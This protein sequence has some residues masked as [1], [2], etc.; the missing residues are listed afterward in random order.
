MAMVGGSEGLEEF[1]AVVE[2]GGFSAAAR[3]LGVSVSHVSRQVAALEARLGTRLLQ[4][5]TRAVRLTESGQIVHDRGQIVAAMLRDLHDEVREDEGVPRGRLRV[6]AGGAYGERRVAPAMVRFAAAHPQ[7]SVE[8]RLDDRHVD[9]ISEG[10]DLAVRLG[11]L[12]DSATVSRRLAPRNMRL[13]AAPS[14]LA[15][16]PA[17]RSIEDLAGHS[18]LSAPDIPWRFATPDGERT[19]RCG[20]RF[21]S[22]S[23]PVLLEAALAGLG[24]TWLAEFYVAEA[25]ASG[26]LVRL[27]PETEV[28]DSGV[29]I[30]YPARE[31]L[32]LRTR[33]AIDWLVR[34][35]AE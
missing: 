22:T 17:P 25:I 7:V 4:R 33:A 5:S 29:W 2:E 3:R 6:A 16:A 28:S 19:L 1:L 31:H 26:A 14:Y 8:L 9:L 10:F 13:C 11:R 23:G 35:L 24:I 18:C 20:G 12:A 21:R 34:E 15:A 32:P 27:L 30:V